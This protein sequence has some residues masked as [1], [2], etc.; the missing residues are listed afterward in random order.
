M[1]FEDGGIGSILGDRILAAE[2][3]HTEVE[4]RSGV[5][6]CVRQ[7]VWLCGSC[8][9]GRSPR[10]G[11][12]PLP[13]WVR[14]LGFPEPTGFCVSPNFFASGGRSTAVFAH[15]FRHGPF[16]EFRLCSLV[17]FGRSISICR[18]GSHGRGQSAVSSLLRSAV[19]FRRLWV[20]RVLDP[21]IEITAIFV[22]LF[23]R[24]PPATP[25][26]NARQ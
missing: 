21:L 17:S 18:F 24:R 4:S 2:A 11:V 25:A 7:W 6:A 5:C 26:R 10:R 16:V 15:I 8:G 12:T 1:H 3:P 14:G 13:G 9:R 19:C 23:L 20:W 22:R